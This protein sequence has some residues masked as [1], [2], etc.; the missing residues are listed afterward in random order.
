MSHS[1][2]ENVKVAV[3]A[4]SGGQLVTTTRTEMEGSNISY[5]PHPNAYKVIYEYNY[6]ARWYPD[7]PGLIHIAIEDDSSGSFSEIASNLRR[8]SSAGTSYKNPRCQ[9]IYILDPWSGSR[10]I[11]L[12][13]KS[14]SDT[15]VSLFQTHQVGGVNSY[16]DIHPT[17]KIYSVIGS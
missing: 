11:R 4:T 17:V 12:T 6:S 15:Q 10:R 14:A 16:L 8:N 3:E 7:V 5:T 1:N 9:Q 13:V 2:I